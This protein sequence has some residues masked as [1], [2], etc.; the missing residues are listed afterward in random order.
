WFANSDPYGDIE[1]LIDG[2][3][4]YLCPDLT[5]TDMLLG[6]RAYEAEGLPDVA[7]NAYPLVFGDPS[8]YTILERSGM[9]IARFQDSNTGI[10]KVEFHFRRRVGGRVTK[11][12]MF[13]VMKIAA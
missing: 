11:P 8:G 3:G 4:N 9:T 7:S 5:D 6:R 13:R 2:N 12:W 10:N 1:L